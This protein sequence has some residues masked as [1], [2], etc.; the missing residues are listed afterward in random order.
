MTNYF[1]FDRLEFRYDPFPI[2]VAK[3]VMPQRIYE[4]MIHYWPPQDL[5]KPIPELGNKLALSEKFN[6]GNYH[7]FISEHAIWKDFHRWIKSRDFIHSVMD[8]LQAH[9]IDL[10]HNK[11]VSVMQRIPKLLKSLLYGRLSARFEFQ[12]M[13]AAGGHL[14]PHTDTPAK[15]VTLVL[16]MVGTDEWNPAWGGGTDVNRPKDLRYSF[17]W[18]NRQ[19]RFED[20][21]IIDTFEFEPNQAVMFIKTF[22]SWHSVRPMV[23]D[24]PKAMRKT[25]IINITKPK[26]K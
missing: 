3:N 23:S 2:G 13:P 1:D 25:L 17:N 16:S 24:D 10:G 21:D 26:F 22:N 6:S 18:L 11:R 5:F 19:G 7:R 8:A 9:H 15:I 4:E 12:I 20:M 14:L